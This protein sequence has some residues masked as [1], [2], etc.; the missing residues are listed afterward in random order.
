MWTM[1]INNLLVK[2]VMLGI[3][4]LGFVDNVSFLVKGNKPEDIHKK[5]QRALNLIERWCLEK[6][7]MVNAKQTELVLF[8][9]KMRFVLQAPSICNTELSQKSTLS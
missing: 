8:T 9:R 2:L 3:Y 6:S 5:M 7:L 4:V 1:V